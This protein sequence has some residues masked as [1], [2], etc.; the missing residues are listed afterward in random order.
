PWMH[1]YAVVVDHPYFGVTGEDG[2]FTIANL[3]AGA[4]TLEAWHPK[5]GTRTLDIKIGT[6]AKA[7]VPARISYK[8]E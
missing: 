1:S 4:Y 8:T 3:P 5:L 7:I 6:G 2:T